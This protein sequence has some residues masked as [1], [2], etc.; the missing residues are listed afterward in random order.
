MLIGITGSISTGK[1]V[2]TDYL[3]KRGFQVIDADK[4][5]KD[6]LNN[7][8]VIS[9]IVRR[10][11][12]S[13]LI[14]GRIDRQALGQLIFMDAEARRTLND[15]IHPRVIEKM[16]KLIQTMT[17]LIFLDIPLLFEARLEHLVNK[18]IVVYTSQKTQ[19]QRLMSRDGIDER[20]ALQKIA[21]QMDIETKRRRADFVV[22]NENDLEQTYLQIDDIIRRLQNEV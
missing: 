14:D 3:I 22:N 21:S 19:L 4:L 1:S 8:E 12:A 6:E 11:G 13:V 15:I 2:V 17:G 16:Q 18:V 5:A 20:F 9:E 7:P 10:F